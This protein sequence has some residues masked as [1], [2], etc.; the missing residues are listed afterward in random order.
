MEA[1]PDFTSSG[2]YP[3]LS[4]LA[5]LF[6]YFFIGMTL[7]QA[8]LQLILQ[9]QGFQ[10]ETLLAEV[11]N[12][13]SNEVH[14]I[15]TLQ[16]LN[17]VAGFGAAGLFAALI[18]REERVLPSALPGL[19]GMLL[20]SLAVML[21]FP[22]LPLITLN[23]D[24]FALPEIMQE[25]EAFLEQAE[26]DAEKLIRALTLSENS[27]ALPWQLFIFAVL[28]A[29]CEELFFRG[30]MLHYFRMRM[31]NH[32]AVWL[33]GLI[34]SLI[35]IQV[36]GFLPRLL[37]GVWLGYLVV[38]S[39]SLIPAVWAHFVFNGTSLVLN[40][41]TGDYASENLPLPIWVSLLS[42]LCLGFCI[43]LMKRLFHSPRNH[44]PEI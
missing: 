1:Q 36:F 16:A 8:L 37:M 29:I 23:A 21:A 13:S 25:T 17:Q 9:A 40:A 11:R 7:A 38:W 35:H 5:L 42:L 31:G 32:T 22:V 12:G 27:P 10:L 19:P 41:A 43:F 34:F 3:L 24:T 20:I 18:Q 4:R 39:G 33:T 14:W 44:E 15:L 28:P 30:A 26:A 6:L 2:P